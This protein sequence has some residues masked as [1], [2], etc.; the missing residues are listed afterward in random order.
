[1]C[2]TA[3]RMNRGALRYGLLVGLSTRPD[4]YQADA[5]DESM[6]GSGPSR[7]NYSHV[8][9]APSALNVDGVIDFGAPGKLVG[10]WYL[11]GMP[12][13]SS[14][15]PYGWTRTIAFVY[16][17]YDPLAVRI[18]IG[19]SVS[20]VGV[21]GIDATAPRPET[22]TPTSGI[23]IHRLYSPF[24]NNP[25]V[26]L[27]LVQMVDASTIKAEVFSGSTITSAQFDANAVT[28]IR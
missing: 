15:G 13:D 20:L 11:K 23:V 7:A 17:Y 8:F 19:G 14:Y 28:F 2:G 9:R 21:W 12:A 22:V 27:M 26:G 18:S 10:D 24:D 6:A 3:H 25:P 4:S 16:D 5:A 1:M